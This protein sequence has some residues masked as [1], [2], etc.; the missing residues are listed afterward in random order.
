LSSIQE[1]YEEG[2]DDG[3]RRHDFAYNNNNARRSIESRFELIDL[4]AAIV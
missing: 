4:D 3:V 1:A 2:E